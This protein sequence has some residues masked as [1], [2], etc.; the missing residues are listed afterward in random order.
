M[1]KFSLKS[2]TLC[3]RG[4]QLNLEIEPC[5]LDLILKRQLDELPLAVAE[6]T[7]ELCGSARADGFPPFFDI[8]EVGPRQPELT[9]EFD[10]AHV[11]S[12]ANGVQ[13][14]A[15]GQRPTDQVLQEIDGSRSLSTHAC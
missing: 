9:S 11:F 15:Q 6:P 12:S 7:S 13:E 5:V 3:R 4:H 14:V 1:I 2:W 10:L 8:A